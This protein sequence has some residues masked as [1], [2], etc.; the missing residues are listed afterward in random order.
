MRRP[1]VKKICLVF[2]PRHRLQR[3]WLILCVVSVFV[4]I[5]LSRSTS[6]SIDSVT[7]LTVKPDIYAN[8]RRLKEQALN[9]YL[10]LSSLSLGVS[11]LKDLKVC[12]KEREHYVPCYNVSANI[13]IGFTNGEEFD[14]HCEVSKGE[15]YC[16]VRPPKDYKTPLSWPVG[17]D[18][19]WNENVKITKE[20]F[21][22]SGSMTKRL[23]LMEENQ[24]SFQSDDG[25]MFDGVK[26]Y[27]HQVAE[28]IGLASDAEFHQ[29]GVRIVLDIGCGFGSFG[30]H[31]LSLKLMTVCMAAYEL[32][33]SQV[34]ISLER[35]LPAIIGNFNSRQLPFPSLSYD[36][37]HCAECG[38]LWDDK[39]GLLLIE[40]DRIL[41]PGGYFV[42]HGSSLSTKKGSMASPIEEFARKICWA[43]IAQQEETYIWQKTTDPQC[44]YSSVQGTI[45]PCIEEREKE[46]IQS[47]Y[48]PL[49]SCMSG[50]T[51]KRWVP[52]QNRSSSSIITSSELEIYGI[53]QDDLNEDFESSLSALRNYWSLLTPLIFSDH[54]KRPGDED[55][56]PPYNMIRNVMDMNARYG[57]LNAA[58][59]EEGKSVWVMNVVPIKA[60]NTLPVIFDQGFAGVLHDWCEP[61]PTYPLTYDMLHANGLLSYLISEQCSITNLLLEMDR[62]LRPEGWVVLSDEARSIEKARSIATQIRWEARVIDLENGS[63]QRILVCQK[64]FVRK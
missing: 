51:S 55:P 9:D 3:I 41:K 15:P 48:Q 22:S 45:P 52:I 17:R 19:I 4:L 34:Q 21:L 1:L 5:V 18:V 16:L 61:F 32:T 56:L 10:D 46:N 59:L 2:G 58:F 49:A 62:I 47:Y 63:N 11:N 40:A 39:D 14:R 13:L 43:F 7:T 24:I 54:P 42:L 37:V 8:Y 33:G 30:A 60:R 28:M 38:V 27:S 36:M 53:Q 64:P 29:A 57:G 20:Q 26:D 44:Y 6:S 25:L 35:G 23:M 31:L 50:T 12:G